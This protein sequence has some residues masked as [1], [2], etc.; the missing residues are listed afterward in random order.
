MVPGA[1]R[2]ALR[3]PIHRTGPVRVWRSHRA[4]HRGGDGMEAALMFVA[5]LIVSAAATG[6]VWF[7]LCMRE[8]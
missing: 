2:F 8:G 6:W 7:A 4:E 3:L 5:G 1:R